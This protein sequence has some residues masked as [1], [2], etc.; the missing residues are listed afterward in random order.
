VNT[1]NA[2]G[3]PHLGGV[4]SGGQKFAVR[5]CPV[6]G[7]RLTDTRESRV[8]SGVQVYIP[9]IMRMLDVSGEK[10]TH[11]KAARLAPTIKAALLMSGQIHKPL[12]TTDP[13]FANLGDKRVA[14]L[15]V[16]LA[17]VCTIIEV[18]KS[19]P[20]G[21]RYARMEVFQTDHGNGL[22]PFTLEHCALVGS[23]LYVPRED[24]IFYVNKLKEGYVDPLCKLFE[25][26]SCI[27]RGVTQY[28]YK[29]D[30][31]TRVTALLAAEF[32]AMVFSGKRGGT[33]MSH[34][35]DNGVALH[36]TPNQQTKDMF[37]IPVAADVQA[38]IHFKFSLPPEILGIDRNIDRVET[39]Q[40]F[41][42]AAVISTLRGVVNH[43]EIYTTYGAYIHCRIIHTYQ[44]GLA[45]IDGE[46]DVNRMTGIFHSIDPLLLSQASDE[47]FAELLD[48]LADTLVK[49]YYVLMRLSLNQKF[50]RDRKRN[51]SNHH[52]DATCL[53]RTQGDLDR[54]LAANHSSSRSSFLK[55]EKKGGRL[56]ACDT[57]GK[58]QTQCIRAGDIH[59]SD[60][61]EFSFLTWPD[62]RIF[63]RTNLWAYYIGTWLQQ[64]HPEL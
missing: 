32:I 10:A 17:T 3:I 64:G 34:L 44:V 16:T 27:P 11:D 20:I 50:V 36:G 29:T 61:G 53:P 39:L 54:I 18:A 4:H 8:I 63:V 46:V 7:I 25:V 12:A 30:P 52:F 48:D 42:P 15:K 47:A 2:L 56:A 40:S 51:A 49:C 31:S 24:V 62:C 13:K 22:Y 28:L 57:T 19:S 58:S 21:S 43:A 38:G 37:R 26:G 55:F 6:K 9:E 1:Y 59:L 5:L 23:L 45:I 33:V 41:F 35:K 60:A 14:E